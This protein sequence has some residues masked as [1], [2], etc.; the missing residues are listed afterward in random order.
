VGTSSS[1]RGRTT[2]RAKGILTTEYR[3][4]KS[5]EVKTCSI[6][7]LAI[8]HQRKKDGRTTHPYR[9]CKSGGCDNISGET[10]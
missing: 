1:T 6:K 4:Q 8:R 2:K 3:K 5:K 9:I 10:N 7:S